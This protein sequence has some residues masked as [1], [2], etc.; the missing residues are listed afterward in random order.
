MVV[1]QIPR[2]ASKDERRRGL[3]NAMLSV[4]T[5]FSWGAQTQR[6]VNPLAN[7]TDEGA[8]KGCV[9]TL[10]AVTESAPK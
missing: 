6:G 7:A 9:A 10:K 1:E 2:S 3:S 8:Q 5:S 4:R